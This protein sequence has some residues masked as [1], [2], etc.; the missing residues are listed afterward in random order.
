MT[1]QVTWSGKVSVFEVKLF[2]LYICIYLIE[3]IE[4]KN[5]KWMHNIFSFEGQRPQD[6]SMVDGDHGDKDDECVEYND[7]GDYGN[8]V[9]AQI[10]NVIS[11]H[12]ECERRWKMEVDT[13]GGVNSHSAIF[14]TA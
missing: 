2:L 9:F 13:S 12:A 5:K 1:A 8:C 6:E 4:L 14:K 3:K 10:T 11:L 7:G